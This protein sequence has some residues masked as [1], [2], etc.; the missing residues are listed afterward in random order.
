M[1]GYF[2]VDLIDPALVAVGSTPPQKTDGS[3]DQA[4]KVQADEDVEAK[5]WSVDD[6]KGS[7][8]VSYS[9]VSTTGGSPP[10][11]SHSSQEVYLDYDEDVNNKKSLTTVTVTGSSGQ[12][13]LLTAEAT[14]TAGGSL[15]DSDSVTDALA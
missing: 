5:L 2:V 14:P 4:G 3:P 6:Y 7:V 9:V 12:G 1:P 13:Y 10:Q 11:L 15:Y 8:T